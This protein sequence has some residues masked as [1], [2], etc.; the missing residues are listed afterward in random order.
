MR[1]ITVVAVALS[2][3]GSLRSSAQLAAARPAPLPA[4][5]IIPASNFIQEIPKG[6]IIADAGLL[7]APWIFNNTALVLKSK[8][9]MQVRVQVP[10]AGSY[11]LFVRSQGEKNTSFKVAVNDKVTAGSFGRGALSWQEGGTFQLPAGPAYV[12][13]T[14]IEMGPVVDVLVL[15]KNA[16]L[17]EEDVRPYQLPEDVQLLRQYTI[18]LSNAVKFGDVNGDGKTDFMVLEPDFSAHV[19]DNSGRELWAYKAPTEYVKERSEFEAPGVL[20]DFDHTGRAE[21]VHWRFIDGKEW[22]VVADGRTG[23]ILRKTAWPTQPLPHVYNNFR[24]AIAHLHPGP[25]NDLVAY[26]DMGGTENVTAYAA[27]LKL[28]WQ[29]TEHRKKDNLGH[30]IYPVDLNGDGLDE[31]L[32]GSLL[33]S[34]QGKEIW[35]RFDLLPDNH[36]HADSYKFID[37]NG[38]GKLDIA[39]ANSETGVFVYEALTGKII[40]Q[41]TAE[42][43]QQL[44]VGN[45]LKN[46][47]GPQVVVGGRTYGSRE[48]GEPGLSSQLYWF[49]KAG[50]LVKKWP[51]NPI[52][53]NPD[54]VRGNWRGDGSTELFWHKFRLNDVGTG[55]LYFHDPVFHMFD[56]TGRGAEEVITLSQGRLSVYG[57]RRAIH[58]GKDSKKN[59]EYLRNSVVNHTH[60]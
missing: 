27:D 39:T 55:E 9:N 31:V 26:T 30:Y 29:H 41:N 6:D 16:S 12:K 11:T 58:G 21:V 57:S 3:F 43:S 47:P 24:L 10:E 13:L 53:G 18:P 37:I 46:V 50:T 38:D 2:C 48:A 45:F 60:Y 23:K 17:K 35:N 20:W 33:L 52:N 19:F 34:T 44:A 54:F 14:R 42:H 25:A 5:V 51:G 32:V 15:S 36:D 40:W 1:K 8:T 49:D 4:T 22:L 56:F 28:L 59:L 7:H